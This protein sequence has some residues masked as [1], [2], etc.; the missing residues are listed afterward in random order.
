MKAADGGRAKLASLLIDAGANLDIQNEHGSTAL[1]EAAYEGGIAVAKVLADA[2][3][4]LG[5]S[6]R[7]RRHF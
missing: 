6:E 4:Q 5:P 7:A 1:M 2:V 3:T